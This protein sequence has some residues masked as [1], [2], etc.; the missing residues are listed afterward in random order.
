M[1]H[2]IQKGGR[3][4]CVGGGGGVLEGGGGVGWGGGGG[5]YIAQWACT[6]IAIG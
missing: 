1:A 3:V 5:Y 6:S 2:G 4:W